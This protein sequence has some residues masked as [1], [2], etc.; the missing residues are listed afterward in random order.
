[1]NLYFCPIVIGICIIQAE[2]VLQATGRQLNK[3]ARDFE[4]QREAD[5]RQNSP[6]AALQRELQRLRDECGRLD[7]ENDDLAENLISKE[8]GL[9]AHIDKVSRLLL[10]L[11]D[12]GHSLLLNSFFLI[13]LYI[14]P[15]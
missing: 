10:C 1:M 6:S 7:K 3:Y 11:K 15:V 12:S 4:K 2:V 5:A 9:Q 13:Y 8:T 14:R